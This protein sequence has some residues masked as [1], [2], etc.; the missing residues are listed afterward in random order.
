V[1]SSHETGYTSSLHIGFKQDLL[2]KTMEIVFLVNDVFDTSY[3]KDDIPIVNGVKQIYSENESNRFARLS[4]VYN[5]GNK[6][7]RG[8]AT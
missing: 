6:K 4:V 8:E 7:N 5:F 2:C 3:L 1:S